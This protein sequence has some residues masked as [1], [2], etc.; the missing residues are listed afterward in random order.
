[1]NAH[2]SDGAGTVLQYCDA[3]DELA[4]V[5]HRNS[6]NAVVYRPVTALQLATVRH[7]F[8]VW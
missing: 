5:Q 7:M 3:I 6:L 2:S 1:M 4:D 8:A